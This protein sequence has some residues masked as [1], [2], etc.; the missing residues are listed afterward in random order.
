MEAAIREKELEQAKVD[1]LIST[2]KVQA[3]TIE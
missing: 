1:A 2:E 3:D